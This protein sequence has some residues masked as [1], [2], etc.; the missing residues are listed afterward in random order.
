VGQDGFAGTVQLS[1]IVTPPGLTA[2]TIPSTVQVSSNNI[3][4]AA[5]TVTTTTA[6]I[7]GNYTIDIIGNSTSGFHTVSITV[8]VT[9]RPDFK[10]SSSA[11]AMII[12]TGGSATSTVT[13]SPIASFTGA[14]ALSTTAPTGFTTSFSTNPITGGTG[15]S[16]LTIIVGTSVAPGSYTLT[17]NG[18][19]GSTTHTTTINV[20]VT[21][22]TK[23]TLV[24]TQT[25]WTHRLSLS[26]NGHTQTFTV[27]IKNTGKTPAYIQ[28]L[29]AGNSTNLTSSF[30][31]GSA[32]A[33]L[34]PGKSVT[35]SLSQPFNTTSI[36]LKF[37]FTIQLLYGTSI[38]ATGNIL[39]PQTIQVAKGTF[40]IAA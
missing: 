6:T 3:T 17:V 4:Q 40:A 28:L 2:V 16:T 14:V 22:S 36:G 29:A 23:T 34:T 27:T 39:S 35:I 15:T 12:Q 21:A 32:V 20:T 26:K 10:L 37:N 25:S 24:V 38:E 31:L 5:V 18:N 7:P 8:T 13:V 9:P 1:A 33:L 11:S 19:S 30:N